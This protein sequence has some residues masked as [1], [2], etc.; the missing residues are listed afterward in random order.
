MEK[1]PKLEY[2]LSKDQ[3]RPAMMHVYIDSDYTVATNA[4]VLVKFPTSEWIANASEI[5]NPFFLNKEEWKMVA[6]K[7]NSS[8]GF[9]WNYH[10]ENDQIHFLG[11]VFIAN[12]EDLDF[13]NYKAVLEGIKRTSQPPVFGLYSHNLKAIGSL[14]GANQPLKFE[15]NGRNR[16]IS[17]SF[18][19]EA[20][21]KVKGIVAPLYDI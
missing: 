10:K 8:E 5:E 9:H 16:H 13:P 19:N 3:L 21:K 6:R 14:L 2:V 7:F 17:F 12:K 4:H 20:Y 18:E 15:L 11:E 1:L